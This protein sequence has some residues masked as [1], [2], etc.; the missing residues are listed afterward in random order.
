MKAGVGLVESVLVPE[1]GGVVGNE[2]ESAV[3]VGAGFLVL[4]PWYELSWR[5]Q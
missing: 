3:F 2:D 1:T 5:R 4:A